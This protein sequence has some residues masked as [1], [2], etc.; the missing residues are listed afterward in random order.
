[1]CEI[2]IH[3]SHVARGAAA[4]L[5]LCISEAVNQV[6]D[7][8][9]YWQE[10]ETWT[11]NQTWIDLACFFPAGNQESSCWV[12]LVDVYDAIQMYHAKEKPSLGANNAKS[13]DLRSKFII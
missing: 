2:I 4:P 11:H 5:V 9:E 12:W 6:S 8:P 7:D 10:L 13:T 3:M 1:M